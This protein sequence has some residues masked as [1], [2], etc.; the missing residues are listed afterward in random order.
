MLNGVGGTLGVG[1]PFVP[2]SNELFWATGCGSVGLA[3]LPG[4]AKQSLEV[5]TLSEVPPVIDDTAASDDSVKVPQSQ[6][7][8]FVVTSDSCNPSGNPLEQ[9]P[10]K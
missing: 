9:V 3:W 8:S 5:A 7:H 2:R 4:I 6:T 1:P 10:L